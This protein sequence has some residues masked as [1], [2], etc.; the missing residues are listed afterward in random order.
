MKHRIIITLLISVVIAAGCSKS[1]T[2]DP[3]TPDSY[4][5]STTPIAFQTPYNWGDEEATKAAELKSDF[6]QDDNIGVV[7]YYLP[8]SGSSAAEWSDNATPNFMYNQE[9][10][11]DGTDWSYS[12]IKYWPNNSYDRLQ[13]FAYYPY[14]NGVTLSDNSA[15]G[16]PSILFKPEVE[17]YKQ[18]D[19]MTAT[20]ALVGNGADGVSFSFEHQLAQ[21]SFQAKHNGSDSYKVSMTGITLDGV[22]IYTGRFTADGFV[23]D[24]TDGV[25]THSYEATSTY[26]EILTTQLGS[27]SYTTITDEEQYG[28][29]LLTPQTLAGADDEGNCQIKIYA[30]FDVTLPSGDSITVTQEIEVTKEHEYIKGQKLNYLFTLDVTSLAIATFDGITITDWVD[31]GTIHTETDTIL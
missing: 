1:D 13:F 4:E 12:P 3:S 26:N 23:W 9:V 21:V 18:V 29:M 31:S 15:E 5:P 11:Y 17:P 16:Y 27:E 8:S 10:V 7:G 6:A 2:P 20:S 22:K 28:I 25:D 14:N 19:F 24:T 30:T